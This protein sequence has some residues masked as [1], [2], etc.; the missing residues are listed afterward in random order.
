MS[1]VSAALF[2]TRLLIL[3]RQ[4]VAPG[5]R[6]R[7]TILIQVTDITTAMASAMSAQYSSVVLGIIFTIACYDVPGLSALFCR[8]NLLFN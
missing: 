7:F 8:S 4:L 5:L 2:D 1:S 6:K 3:Y